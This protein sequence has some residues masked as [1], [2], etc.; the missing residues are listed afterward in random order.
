MKLK[1]GNLADENVGSRHHVENI[2]TEWCNG[3]MAT[4]EIVGFFCKI[5]LHPSEFVG[6]KQHLRI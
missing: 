3:G 2:L 5:R 6:A 4:D 1:I